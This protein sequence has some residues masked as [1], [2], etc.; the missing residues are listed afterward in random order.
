MNSLTFVWNG[1]T[2]V[3]CLNVL[4]CVWYPTFVQF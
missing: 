3:L 4:Q 1:Y 2:S